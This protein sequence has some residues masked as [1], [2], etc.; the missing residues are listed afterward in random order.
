MQSHSLSFR[1]SL[2]ALRLSLLTQELLEK[3]LLPRVHSRPAADGRVLVTHLVQQAVNDVEHQTRAGASGREADP[4]ARPSRRR[5][6]ACTDNPRL[7]APTACA[8]HPK[9]R[10]LSHPLASR[11][12]GSGGSPPKSRPSPPPRYPP[13]PAALP[14]SA[15]RTSPTRSAASAA[16]E[17]LSARTRPR[18]SVCLSY[19]CLRRFFHLLPTIFRASTI[20][21]AGTPESFTTRCDHRVLPRPV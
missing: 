19:A 11:G 4:A 20:C 1:P 14:R 12:R 2:F 5:L 13:A 7:G 15:R 21:S 3:L 9:G 18:Y 16:R 6:P 10:S 8:A 17:G